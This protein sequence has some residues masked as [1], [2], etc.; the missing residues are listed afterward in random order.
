M[1]R[2]NIWREMKALCE[3]ASVAPSKVFPHSLPRL[4]ARVLLQHLTTTWQ[5]WRIFSGHSNI[6][7]TDLYHYHR[8][9]T[10]GKMETMR[11]VI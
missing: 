6:S 11:L 3:R 9:R 4:F 10:S 2:S 8:R 5:N 1:N 7:T